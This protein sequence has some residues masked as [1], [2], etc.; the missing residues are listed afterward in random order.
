[1]L[2]GAVEV[3]FCRPVYPR[4]NAN[5][6]AHRPGAVDDPAFDSSLHVIHAPLPIKPDKVDAFI[7][8]VTLDGLGST[9]RSPAACGLMSTKISTSPASCTS[10]KSTST[11]RHSSTTPKRRTSPMA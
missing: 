9:R 1:M 11:R 8:A 7:E 3:S 4:G 5:W 10:T 2:D 6:D